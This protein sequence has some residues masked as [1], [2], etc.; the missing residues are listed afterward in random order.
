MTSPLPERARFDHGLT[1]GSA[2]ISK[3]A[4]V[5]L[6]EKQSAKQSARHRHTSPAVRERLF[7]LGGILW[8]EGVTRK[9]K[10]PSIHIETTERSAAAI[11]WPAKCSREPTLPLFSWI[12]R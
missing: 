1:I 4:V 9:Q 5:A 2:M 3:V 12:H 10:P 8:L 7:M 11:Y 6:A